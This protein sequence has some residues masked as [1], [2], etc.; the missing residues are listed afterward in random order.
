MTVRGCQLL[1]YYCERLVNDV[2]LGHFSQ[3]FSGWSVARKPPLARLSQ[4]TGSFPEVSSFLKF[5][6]WRRTV[7]EPALLGEADES[8]RQGRP[9]HGTRQ[10][11]WCGD[12]TSSPTARALRCT[13]SSVTRPRC[14]S[15]FAITSN[16]N[17]AILHPYTWRVT[18][19]F[20]L[21]G[22]GERIGTSSAISEPGNPAPC[23]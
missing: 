2:L 10:Q 5:T 3:L 20:R 23:F 6:V 17:D 15:R 9:F 19:C 11:C 1:G 12:C 13:A 14:T 16:S 18:D 4:T 22:I 7:L 21:T 8:W